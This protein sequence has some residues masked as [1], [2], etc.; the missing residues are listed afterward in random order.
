MNWEKENMQVIEE[1][2]YKKNTKK[3]KLSGHNFHYGVKEE[4]SSVELSTFY[5]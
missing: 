2:N 4:K 3:K 1:H 5:K